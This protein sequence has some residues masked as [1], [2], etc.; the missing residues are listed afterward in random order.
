MCV[1]V[2]I[3]SVGLC[4]CARV[5]ERQGMCAYVHACVRACKCVV[6][7]A[8]LVRGAREQVCHNV[9]E[10]GAVLAHIGVVRAVCETERDDGSSY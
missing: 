10:R 6:V 9:R 4:L 1:C 3:G 7:R 2:C 8:V 5:I